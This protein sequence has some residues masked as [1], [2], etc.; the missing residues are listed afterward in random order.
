VTVDCLG[1]TEHDI[2]DMLGI[3]VVELLI[4]PT[5]GLRSLEQRIALALLLLDSLI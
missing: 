2:N 3:L 4:P 5:R 1:T